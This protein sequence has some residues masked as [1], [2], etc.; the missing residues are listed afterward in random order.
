MGR[1]T[2][3]PVR[4]PARP[5]VLVVD[6]EPLARDC[7]RLALAARGDVEIVGECADGTEAVKA[8]R[9]LAPDMVFLDVQMPELDGFGVIAEVGPSDM[10]PVVFVTAFDAHALRAF[11]VHALDYVLKPF[12]DERL[13][14]AFDHALLRSRERRDGAL[15]RQLADLVRGWEGTGGAM[16]RREGAPDAPVEGPPASAARKP[17]FVSRFT[18]R[19]DTGAQFVAAASVDWIEAE[20]NYV[21]LRVGE[22]RHRVRGTLRDVAARLD[23]RM[24]VRI[25]RSTIVNIDRIRELQP[26]FG[27]DYIAILRS[28]AKLKVSRRHVAQL[29]RPM[30]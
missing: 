11:E 30:A 15:G 24:F 22:Q 21:V 25:H 20:G 18:V 28:G 12:D 13:L 26:W 7:I 8:I 29:L 14:A 1:A 6:D 10:P 5:Q 4:D 27:G 3:P 16:V 23:P 2:R 17:A 9:S 19:T